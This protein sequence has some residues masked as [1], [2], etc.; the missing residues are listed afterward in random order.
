LPAPTMGGD[1]DLVYVRT[2]DLRGRRLV[3]ACDEKILGRTFR[4]GRLRLEVSESFYKGALL[5]MDDAVKLVSDADIANLTGR[6][7]VDAVLR[8]GLA[9]RRAVITV[10]G[11]PHLQILRL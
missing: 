4:E 3:A 7:I 1:D 9:D 10:S 2:V 5:S 11:I 6:A 8:E